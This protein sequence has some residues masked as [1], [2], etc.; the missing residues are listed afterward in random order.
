MEVTALPLGA[1]E[2]CCYVVVDRYP[3]EGEATRPA[4]VIDPGDEG[5]RV[6][7]TLK[8]LGLHPEMVLL[9]HAHADHIGGVE[10]VLASR[11][12]TILACSAET[13]RRIADPRLNLSAMMGMPI[14]CRNAT[15]II[16][17]GD[18][19]TAGGLAWR[20][21][22]VPG[23]DPG[24]LVYLAGDDEA[25]FAGDTVFAGSIGRSD[26]PGG[27]GEALVEGIRLLLTGLNPD[28][29]I[30]PGHGPSTTV[31]RELAYNPFLR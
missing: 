3:A 27:D 19:F 29:P 16:A 9:T 6:V 12:G 23:H 14:A 7:R 4:V 2:T 11:P 25:V 24:E 18:H 1:F 10:E 13:S 30:Y 5:A 20:A 28:V 21:V 17:D 22:D 15:K 8:K 31:A 26:F